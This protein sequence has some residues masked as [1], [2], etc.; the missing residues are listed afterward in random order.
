MYQAFIYKSVI[1]SIAFSIYFYGC[2]IE[3]FVLSD[4]SDEKNSADNKI[5]IELSAG[6]IADLTVSGYVMTLK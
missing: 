3:F 4:G 6:L 2:D 1:Q 5:K